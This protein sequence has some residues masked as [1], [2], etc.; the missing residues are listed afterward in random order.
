MLPL[1]KLSPLDRELVLGMQKALSKSKL[2]NFGG[3]KVVTHNTEAIYSL[4]K[5]YNQQ[6]ISNMITI[7]LKDYDE[8][9]KE[10]FL[11]KLK[12]S[13]EASS[14]I[15]RQ[16]MA[17]FKEKTKDESRIIKPFQA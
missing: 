10:K 11:K 16:A 7:I 1:E 14:G 12:D 4:I 8:L 9:D 6:Y 17:I 3:N 5:M 15:A 13:K 2:Q